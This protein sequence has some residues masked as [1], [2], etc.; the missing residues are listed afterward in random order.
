VSVYQGTIDWSKVAGSGI[1][2]AFIRA[3]DGMSKDS[4]FQA[5]WTGAKAAGITRGAYQYFRAAHDGAQQANQLCDMLTDA[6]E[7]A[8]A[9]DV[10]TMDGASSSVLASRLQAW[11]DTVKSRTGRT[12]IIYTSPGLWDGYHLPSFAA[13]TLWVANW[14]VSKPRL[15]NGW[16]DW[17][18]WQYRNDSSVPGIPN[19]VDADLF[20]GSEDDLKNFAKTGAAPAP[21]TTVTAPPST[22]AASSSSSTTGLVGSLGKSA[23]V[24]TSSVPDFDKDDGD[25]I[26]RRGAAGAT[27]KRLQTLLNQEGANLAVDGIYGPETE[28]A[29]KQFQESHDCTVDGVVGPQTWGAIDKATKPAV[30][31][32][33]T[34]PLPVRPSTGPAGP[35]GVSDS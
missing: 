11:V 24:D 15:P 2:F 33:P 19:R 28:A 21:G 9:C 1:K 3:G 20:H 14:A 32:I 34:Q 5:N 10:E 4:R 30:K 26:L 16:S 27:V 18:F 6:G 8:P 23:D 12:P 31:P 35:L 13:E 7:L 29:V 17:T 25:P 22:P